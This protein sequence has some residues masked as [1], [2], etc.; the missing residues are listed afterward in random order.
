MK[1]LENQDIKTII[2]NQNSFTD[3]IHV[4]LLICEYGDKPFSY[5]LEKNLQLK[6]LID[7]IY[8]F[9]LD[10]E[11]NDNK[12]LKEKIHSL[13]NQYNKEEGLK[14][15]YT[16]INSIL[17]SLSNKEED[18]L[19]FSEDKKSN[20]IKNIENNFIKIFQSL[21]GKSYNKSFIAFKK[22][23]KPNSR[24]KEKNSDF[25]KYSTPWLIKNTG[26]GEFQTHSLFYK[27]LDS[28]NENQ[29]SKIRQT[30][31]ETKYAIKF[32]KN[33]QT[34]TRFLQ[35]FDKNIEHNLSFSEQ[36]LDNLIF[37]ELFHSDLDDHQGNIIIQNDENKKIN[38]K[39]IDF[40]NINYSS[41]IKNIFKEDFYIKRILGFYI[42]DH[43]IKKNF[44][45]NKITEQIDN[46]DFKINN[47]QDLEL[48]WS[49]VKKFN[50]NL[51][52]DEYNNGKFN[53]Y[54]IGEDIYKLIIDR[55]NNLNLEELFSLEFL[56]EIFI[57]LYDQNV[58]NKPE[59]QIEQKIQKLEYTISNFRFGSFIFKIDNHIFENTE[60]LEARPNKW[61]NFLLIKFKLDFFKKNDNF[62]SEEKFDKIIC[63]ERQKY[64]NIYKNLNN[65][66][67]IK[68][69]EDTLNKEI[70][71]SKKY[72]LK[73]LQLYLFAQNFK[74][75]Y[76]S[77]DQ[78]NNS[79]K[80]IKEKIFKNQDDLKSYDDKERRNLLKLQEIFINKL[81]K[82][83]GFNPQNENLINLKNE[84][85][86]YDNRHLMNELSSLNRTNLEPKVNI[87]ND[88][89]SLYG[90]ENLK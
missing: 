51:K 34:L 78:I 65:E 16:E 69:L 38:L 77:E 15:F 4:F 86:N 33:S 39:L 49:I 80:R 44:F 64:E 13:L 40:E 35:N 61:I 19:R 5:D 75:T 56:T 89:L 30:D 29:I 76:A 6:K 79:L 68:Y 85:C 59:N 23:Q 8:N 21:S 90:R 72:F 52:K 55:E 20:K 11:L 43:L 57:H 70:D 37:G 82:L 45:L 73:Y 31:D 10:G 62:V 32:F 71:F 53:F 88:L 7:S 83:I 25:L 27:L 67:K 84:T 26:S 36:S 87:L 3:K 12:S 14:S 60:I 48:I 1:F 24:R 22:I 81:D 47:F 28:E 18:I 41:C 9:L 2:S 58:K 17:N 54:Y 50:I 63:E 46:K 74:N 66:A 42:K